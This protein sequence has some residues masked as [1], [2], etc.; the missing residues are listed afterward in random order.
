MAYTRVS[1]KN[2]IRMLPHVD[3]D[4]A[5]VRRKSG[6][7]HRTEAIPMLR[8]NVKFEISETAICGDFACQLHIPSNFTFG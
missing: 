2:S 6:L 8:R 7:G 5:S 4:L 3:V 1:R